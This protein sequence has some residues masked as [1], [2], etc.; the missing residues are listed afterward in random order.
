[1]KYQYRFDFDDGARVEYEVR[2]NENSLLLETPPVAQPPEWT[3]LGFRQCPNCT[4]R[5]PGTQRCPIAENLVPVMDAWG[6]VASYAPLT[7]TVQGEIREVRA[8]TTAQ[9]A[10]SSLLG[11]I[12]GASACPHMTFFRPM[13]Y[14]H[15]PLATPDETL[16]RATSNF[17]LMQYFTGR[18]AGGQRPDL[19]PLAEIY[20]QVRIVNE[21]LCDRLRA[22]GQGD[23]STNALVKLHLLSCALPMSL[24][25]SL[26]RIERLFLPVIDALEP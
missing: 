15:L 17:F 20:R 2:I 8:R 3:A 4:L 25:E 22:L 10:L 9:G 19:A 11:V 6:D 13:A 23:A 5:E 12:M 7:L 14:F 26:A 18:Q 1:M 21:C 24:E 16:V